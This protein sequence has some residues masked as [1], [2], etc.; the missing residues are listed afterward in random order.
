[1]QADDLQNKETEMN[2]MEKSFALTKSEL[3]KKEQT[4]KE[5]THKVSVWLY[6]GDFFFAYFLWFFPAKLRA[7]TF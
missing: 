3:A 1:M 2:E 5:L 4:R 6:S 7:L